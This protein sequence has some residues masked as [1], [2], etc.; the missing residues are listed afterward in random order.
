MD[1]LYKGADITDDVNVTRCICRDASCGRADSL[2]IEFDHAAAWYQ[3]QPQ[4]DDEIAVYLDGYSSGKMYVNTFAPEGDK[5]RI[6]ATALPSSARRLAWAGY[7]GM[8]FADIMHRCAV[9]AGLDAALYG[10]EGKMRDPYLLRD[11]KG[12]A[13]F[14]DRLAMREGIAL[15]ASNGKFRA[16]SVEYAQ[17]LDAVCSLWI[18]TT[19][20]G[21]I[22]LRQESKKY[23]SLTVQALAR[24]AKVSAIDSAAKY[25]SAQTVPLPAYDTA[26][27]GRWARGTLLMHNRQ[28]EHLK[29]KT[30]FN[31]AL[32]AMV[33]V[34]VESPQDESASITTTGAWIVHEV[35]HDLL[36]RSSTPDLVRVISTVK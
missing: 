5:F 13:A 24:N 20:E 21:V 3:W 33:R 36:N 30:D 28:Q 35:E 6:L 4:V 1:I 29:I 8:T 32:S 12:C 15:K 11:Y 7:E 17:D 31:P 18:D 19:L 27:A 25:G 14:M 26:Q 23:S 9:E 22:H 2:D 34:D 10:T 16:I